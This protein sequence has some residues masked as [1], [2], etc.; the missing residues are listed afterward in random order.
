MIAIL[1]G[2]I[3]FSLLAFWAFL[4]NKI[5]ETVWDGWVINMY[6]NALYT[7]PLSRDDAEIT[8]TNNLIWPIDIRFDITWN[9]RQLIA[10]G[11]MKIDSYEMN[12][13][14][15]RCNDGDSEVR[16]SNP[17]NEQAIVCTFD[18]VKVY[19]I[20]GFYRW[21]D[22]LWNE[23][24][25]S[26]ELSAVEIRW[27]VDIRTQ[28]NTSGQDIMTLDAS[29][30]KLLGNPRWVKIG[31]NWSL[32]I[33]ETS[34]S[35]TYETTSQ[36]L[37]VGLKIFGD[38]FDRVFVVE[39]EQRSNTQGTIEISPSEINPLEYTFALK[40][41]SLDTTNVVSI[42]WVLDDGSLICKN[43]AEICTHTFSSYGERSIRARITLSDKTTYSLE[44][45]FSI[46]EPILLARHFTITDKT[47]KKLNTDES[48]DP[49]IKAYVLENII[50]PETL[51]FD[52]RDV[53]SSNPGYTLKEVKWKFSDGKSIQEKEGERV[54]FEIANTF[55]Y[56]LTAT[57]TFVRNGS[58]DETKT[59]R[60][61]AI[62]DVEHKSLIPRIILQ[63]TWD[64]VPARITVDGSQ[65]R[66]ENGEIK[67]F[68]Y[69]FGEWKP[70]AEWDA[71]QI[72][73][74]TTPGEKEITLTIINESGEKAQLKRVIVLKEAPKTLDFTTSLSPAIV[75]I[76]VD[77][78][79]IGE[80][81]Q[82]ESY[83]WNFGD[84]TPTERWFSVSHTFTNAWEYSVTLTAI[85]A[86]GTQKQQTKKFSVVSSLE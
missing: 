30:L 29:T 86:D 5:G 10:N 50:P 60:D 31:A 39:A 79:V 52:A 7:N 73:E 24:E 51:T 69:N 47:G 1:V 4:F 59:A 67:K 63:T 34:S 55:R 49:V 66:S 74:Y 58:T 84:N 85:Y 26:M 65:S 35:V 77:F 82:V 20:R 62:I 75:S 43:Q 40:N 9:A 71:I 3:L 8:Q 42:E 32:G 13:D 27:L 33:E 64:Y 21:T 83:I 78:S 16:G 56:T 57:Y 81:G 54:T 25:V 19:D 22:A 70:D 41:T 11:G 46:D 15:A 2:I 28:K 12:F 38:T 80:S 18:S 44:T 76:P 48:F 14:G 45:T 53:V 68:I 36:P 6:D 72:Y 61:S 37:F 17:T 23:K